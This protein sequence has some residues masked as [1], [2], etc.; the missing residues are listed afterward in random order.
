MATT[1]IFVV[2]DDQFLGNLIKK[3]LEKID[4]L[5]VTHFTTP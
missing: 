5:D 1:K 3:T 4:N 2:E